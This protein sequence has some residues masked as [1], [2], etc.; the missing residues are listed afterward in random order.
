MICPLWGFTVAHCGLGLFGFSANSGSDGAMKRPWRSC[1]RRS[2][3]K[4]GRL[5]GRR[6]S[7]TG[8]DGGKPEDGR[9]K[10][11]KTASNRQTNNQ[12]LEARGWPG[13]TPEGSKQQ[14]NKQAGL[15]PQDRLEIEPLHEHGRLLLENVL[16][17]AWGTEG[18]PT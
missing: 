13:Q 15:N 9:G 3:N 2:E 4:Q 8:T 10:L 6:W 11:L 1:L 18:F 12:R 5:D 17:C 14:T 16:H 7:T